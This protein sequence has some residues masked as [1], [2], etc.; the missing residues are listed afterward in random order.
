[1]EILPKEV[2]ELAVRVNQE[3]Q[4]EVSD[5]LEK[6]FTET[7]N[8]EKQVDG[9]EV[10]G[11]ED[12]MSIQL[13]DTARKNIKTARLAAEK[14]FDAKREDVQHRM[15]DYK[16]EDSLWLKAKQ[17][18]Q[19]KT[20]AIEEKAEWKAKYVE[21]FEKEQ[22][23]LKIQLRLE[24][25]KEFSN[26]ITSAQIEYLTDDMFEVF[27]N[28]IKNSYFDKIEAE[29]LA[30]QERVK[31]QM[32]DELEQT[33]K[34]DIAQ[35]AMFTK[36]QSYDLRN[37]SSDDFNALIEGLKAKLAGYQ[38]EQDKIRQENERLKLEA[39]KAK[40]IADK[41]EAENKVK[42]KAEQEARAKLEAQIKAK[43][44]AEAKI[45]LEEE[46]KLRWQSELNKKQRLSNWINELTIQAPPNMQ[47]DQDVLDII[48]KFD[49]FKKWAKNKVETIK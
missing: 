18:M 37:M 25:L 49:G 27:F 48:S 46:A 6:I 16:L 41:I 14:V 19:L 10:K 9:I 34:N 33:R 24:R 44:E 1:M 8:W 31:K 17:I 35:Y 28:G 45:K 3:K 38:L 12:K 43:E 22:K 20:K 36:G 23:E 39:D 42:L 5:I 15:L 26:E 29:K 32:L 21:R 47:N 30:E 13:A 11:I 7:A 2:S 40:V 4:K